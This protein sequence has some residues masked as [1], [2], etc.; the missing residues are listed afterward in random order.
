MLL[1]VLL[2]A[3]PMANVWPYQAK[4]LPDGRVEYAYDLTVVKASPPATEA[5]ASNGEKAAKAFLAQLPKEVRVTVKPGAPVTVGGGRGLEPTP[6]VSAFAQVSDAPYASSD[7]LGRTPRA[8]LHAPLAPE[9]PKVMLPAEAVLWRVRR[10]EDGA[11][12]AL[13]LDDDAL[14]AGLWPKVVERSLA[15]RRTLDADG[16]EGRCCSR[17]GCW[18]PTPAE[19]RRASTRL[20][21]ATPRSSRQWTSNWRS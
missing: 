7:P 10:F 20:R 18:W 13:L 19:S 21:W 5:I 11:L 2:A 12:A 1:L 6:L 4:H 9:E 17:P 14:G 8:R 3:A 16:A 15:K